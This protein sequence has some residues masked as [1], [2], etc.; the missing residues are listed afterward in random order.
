MKSR[1]LFYHFCLKMRETDFSQALSEHIC[2]VVTM[3]VMQAV[4]HHESGCAYIQESNTAPGVRDSTTR[5]PAV[6]HN[7]QQEHT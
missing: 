7:E 3:P 4:W 6:P 2:I 1:T 5:F